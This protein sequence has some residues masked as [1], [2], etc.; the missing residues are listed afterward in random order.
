M[1]SL[2]SLVIPIVLSAVV[3]FIASAILHMV[4]PFHKNDLKKVPGEDEFLAAIR[5]FNLPA[6]DYAAPHA[7]SAAAMKDPA[8]IEKR[9]KGPN[10]LM[11]LTP[12]APPAMGTHLTQ[13]FIYCVVVSLFAAYVASR[14]L[15]VATEYI[16]VFRIVG[17]V[18]FM[19]Y[20]LGLVQNS[21]WY[22]K[23]WGATFRSVID[24][25]AYALLTAGVF[26]WMWPGP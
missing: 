6:G 20:A 24:G 26:G 3:V 13:W 4:I 8:F 7:D 2:M 16:E 11:T 17:T 1:V 22:M 18:A 5:Q 21:I 10:V 15:P 23:N 12:G 14:T 19:G 9:Q 25:L